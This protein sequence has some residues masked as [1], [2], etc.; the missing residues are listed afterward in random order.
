MVIRTALIEDLKYIISLANKESKSI[1][2]IPKCAYEAAIIGLKPS[3]HR[4]SDTCNDKIFMCIENG[5]RVGFVMASFGNVVK[6]NQIC[7]QEDARMLER[8]KALLD[9]VINH[10]YKRGRYDYSCGCAD[11]LESNLFW[12]A[13][14][15]EKVN[16][17]HGM[18][19]SN[20]WKESS[21]RKV[22]IYSWQEM[23][24]FTQNLKEI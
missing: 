7:I 10:G 13:M 20:T 22:N 1:G 6:I 8:G 17:R 24:L 5:D 11:D 19:F 3:I 23:S 15:W 18:H 2:F 9:A 12:K 14:G 16:E 4:W 21:K